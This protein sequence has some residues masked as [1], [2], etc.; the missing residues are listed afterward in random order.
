MTPSQSAREGAEFTPAEFIQEVREEREKGFG[1]VPLIGAGLAAPSGIPLIREVAAYLRRCIAMS[2]GIDVDTVQTWTK[3][4]AVSTD[5]STSATWPRCRIW[6]P[7]RDAWPPF[8]DLHLPD[9]DTTDWSERLHQVVISLHSVPLRPNEYHVFREAWGAMSEWRSSLHFLTRIAVVSDGNGSSENH[10]QHLQLLS[11]EPDVV[12]RF[13]RHVVLG[14]KPTLGHR[15]LALLG[16]VLRCKVYLTTNFDDLAERA[17]DEIGRTLSPFEVH[18]STGLPS[19][20][21]L[22][23][24]PVIVKLHGGRH[25]LRADYSLDD[26]PVE[27]D[28][29]NFVS[30]FVEHAIQV[31]LGNASSSITGSQGQTQQPLGSTSDGPLHTRNHLLV[32][33]IS[34]AEMRLNRLIEAA[35]RH[36]NADFRIFWI[37]HTRSDVERIRHV[38]RRFLRDSG[39][40]DDRFVVVR[41]P[42]LDLLFL[43]MFQ[44]VTDGLP[45]AG[46]PF[47]SV[48]KLAVPVVR[49]PVSVVAPGNTSRNPRDVFC[50]KRE[51]LRREIDRLVQSTSFV[52]EPSPVADR[53]IVFHSDLDT[54]GVMSIAADEFLDRL[55]TATQCIWLDLDEIDSSDDLFEQILHAVARKAGVVDW[56]PLLLRDDA[57]YRTREIQR[58]TNN[59]SRPWV[60]FLNARDGAGAHWQHYSK[61]HDELNGWLDRKYVGESPAGPDDDRS[62]A[63]APFLELCRQLCGDDCPNVVIVLLCRSSSPDDASAD[64]QS[65]LVKALMHDAEIRRR[66][67]A[68]FLSLEHTCT[69]F[70]G[71]VK[72]FLTKAKAWIKD[73]AQS[74][75]DGDSQKARRRFLYALTVVERPR[76]PA[77]LWSWSF[78]LRD[79]RGS[80]S[81][82]LK[83]SRKRCT[84]TN[85]WIADL[86]SRG[87]LREKPG[88]FIWLHCKYRDALR[89]EL[90]KRQDI[91]RLRMKI[92]HGIAEWYRKLFFASQDALAAFEAV[93]HRCNNAAAAIDR[94]RR[95]LHGDQDRGDKL[96]R[97]CW[98]RARNAL[99]DARALLRLSK[100]PA[101][102]AG[103]SKGYCRRLVHLR[104]RLATM[105]EEPSRQ[106]LVKNALSADELSALLD[107][108]RNVKLETLRMKRDLARECA[109]NLT[110]IQRLQQQAKE[111]TR[112]YFESTP[113]VTNGPFGSKELPFLFMGHYNN[114]GAAFELEYLGELGTLLLATRSYS[115]AEICFNYAYRRFGFPFKRL[116]KIGKSKDSSECESNERE[117]VTASI[118]WARLVDKSETLDDVSMVP[119]RQFCGS[120]TIWEVRHGI[121]KILQR[122]MQMFLLRGHALH[123]RERRPDPPSHEAEGAF[124]SAV[125]CYRA[126]I[127]ILR[128]I[129]ERR[130]RS[131]DD[132]QP[133][134]DDRQ[135]LETQYALALTFLRDYDRAYQRLN[136]AASCLHYSGA[137]YQSMQSAII[138]LHRAELLTHQAVFSVVDKSAQMTLIGRNRRD[139]LELLWEGKP[140]GDL[141]GRVKAQQS[142]LKSVEQQVWQS[143]AFLDD[144]WR[145]LTSA[146]QLLESNRK[147][148]WWGTWF[149][150]LRL[151]VV[152]LKLFTSLWTNLAGIP[153]CDA[154]SMP[155]GFPSVPERT[156]DNA[157]RMVRLDVYRLARIV[158]SF[159]N[160]LFAISLHLMIDEQAGMLDWAGSGSEADLLRQRQVSM[161]MQAEK[162]IGELVERFDRKE[163]S[164]EFK[165]SPL[166]ASVKPYVKWVIDEHRRV[167]DL[168]DADDFSRI[169]PFLGHVSD[170]IG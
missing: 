56:M 92:T 159:V 118:E 8:G 34:G 41:Y 36:L 84:L 51:E 13:F 2:L 108:C 162:A 60:I 137:G 154:E 144:A 147:N 119:E 129:E 161:R 82:P 63:T 53:L 101:L 75:N 85:A 97:L 143:I 158:E 66:L 117:F 83:L 115:R 99:R 95:P 70:P 139:L 130:V 45:R 7:R 12:D 141:V 163:N 65:R 109:E 167:V 122:H 132:L 113:V 67:K 3:E 131:T 148:V 100:T 46:I 128:F 170:P 166:D 152:E 153:F 50:E 149:F 64:D 168:L 23:P 26:L 77:Q 44:H 81:D 5:T 134:L 124:R 86:S 40:T 133:V 59:P 37:C 96:K 58:I 55:G 14:K 38:R 27:S 165:G 28:F 35:W 33:G 10:G 102:S 39:R 121:I 9:R 17:F 125:A 126:A 107:E 30:Y 89:E 6:N 68:I 22:Q 150:E 15:M 1:F 21:L 47:P 88:G 135:R 31:P 91:A 123:L 103:F 71:T 79:R 164:D 48:P 93:Y 57:A 72:D 105:V 76:Y 69:D 49:R 78:H 4:R 112:P 25:R 80:G 43:E 42:F 98:V 157:L 54:H 74:H 104:N 156:L 146:E 62:A 136:E 138:E 142:A 32:M 140:L 29:R 114:D 94:I 111:S 11:P 145:T 73:G 106:P 160:S 90:E 61:R 52:R 24:Q 127:E 151:K 18:E 16:D 110:A 19:F 155:R 116:R 169:I 20:P 120:G 87:L